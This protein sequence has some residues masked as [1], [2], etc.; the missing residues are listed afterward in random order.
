MTRLTALAVQ[1]PPRCLGMDDALSWVAIALR[2]SLVSSRPLMIGMT[3]AAKAADAATLP[4]RP[5]ACAAV[6]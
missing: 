2:D 1:R 5:L 6:G 4:A 3:L